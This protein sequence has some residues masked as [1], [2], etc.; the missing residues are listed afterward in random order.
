MMWC[1]VR[2]C[3]SNSVEFQIMGR[4]MYGVGV[5]V[6]NWRREPNQSP[7]IIGFAVREVSMVV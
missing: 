2:L 6:A 3:L 7:L 5:G 1:K 4:W